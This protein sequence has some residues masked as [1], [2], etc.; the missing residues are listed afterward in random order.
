MHAHVGD[1]LHVRGRVVGQAEHA[2]QVVE[3]RE[4]PSGPAIY[5]IR[6]DDGNQAVISPGPD[7][8]IEH[9]PNCPPS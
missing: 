3:V 1:R 2:G 7:T 8:F 4:Q 6:Y 9:G 5:V